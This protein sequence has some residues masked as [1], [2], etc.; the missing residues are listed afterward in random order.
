ML[1]QLITTYIRDYLIG[2]LCIYKFVEQRSVTRSQSSQACSPRFVP[3]FNSR[4]Y[5]V[6][7]TGKTRGQF[8]DVRTSKLNRQSRIILPLALHF[9]VLVK[10]PIRSAPTTNLK[11]DVV[12]PGP[13]WS[14]RNRS[15][16]PRHPFL[17]PRRSLFA[18]TCSQ[19]RCEGRTMLQPTRSCRRGSE[20]L[21][22]RQVFPRD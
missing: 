6:S 15:I 3:S 5:W 22:R 14:Q 1:I 13:E 11:L 7:H 12:V 10:P 19:T 16:Y 21:D 2:P 9:K 4:I 20:S 17:T 18:L 8:V